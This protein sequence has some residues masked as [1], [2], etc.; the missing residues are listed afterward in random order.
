MQRYHL[1]ASVLLL[2]ALGG[3]LNATSEATFI[4]GR[5]QMLCDGVWPVCKGKFA[6][7]LFDQEHYLQ[8]TFPGTRKFLVETI[9]GDWVIMVKL[10]LEDRLAP[11][12]ETEVQ[13]YEP[14]C[15]D[16]YRYQLSKN[17]VAGN[18]FEQAGRSQVFSVERAVV[19]AGD[20]LVEVYSDAT[21]RYDLRVEIHK[22]E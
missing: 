17:L 7:C 13:W 3:C 1:I 21:C 12:T 16:E 11:G 6:G 2:P 22:K 10:F 15:A 8:G 14:G 5:D 9:P 4:G 18:L 19:E 20:H